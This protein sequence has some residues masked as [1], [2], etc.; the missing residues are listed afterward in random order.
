[1]ANLQSALSSCRNMMVDCIQSFIEPHASITN[2]EDR[3]RSRL[4]NSLIVIYLPL[5]VFVIFF[6]FIITPDD[7][8]TTVIITSMGIAV[9]FLIYL[10]GR[11]G[12]YRLSVYVTVSLGFGVIYFNAL[13]SGP[14]HFEIAYLLFLPLLGIVMFSLQDVLKIYIVAMILLIIFLTTIGDIEQHTAIDLF[15]FL[16]LAQGF[17]LFASYQRDRLE[18]NRRELILER[19]RR[20]L[21]AELIGNVSHDLKNPLTVIRNSVY[22]IKQVN[23]PERL[24]VELEKITIQ[25]KRLQGLIDDMLTISQMDHDEK[26]QFSNV[27]LS[28]LVDSVLHQLSTSAATK[29]IEVKAHISQANCSVLG[30]YE[31]L[32]RLLINLVENALNYTPEGGRVTV[33]LQPAAKN[34]IKLEVQDT[35]IGLSRE[36]MSKI[37]E[38][39]YRAD[40]ARAAHS[41][42]TGLGLSIVQRIVEHHDGE[43]KVDS[44]VGHGTTF[45]ILLPI[46]LST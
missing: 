25:T 12:R 34:N 22:F 31:E 7:T 20:E 39:F 23:T 27:D 14:P 4:L 42:G 5:A 44:R 13:N 16:L 1:M 45:C 24:E 38:R 26:P 30:N 8:T 6:R 37:F 21:V 32:E 3:Y 35:G 9:V 11:I 17:V 36:E 46:S 18:R 40:K 19:E 29:Q 2:D 28:E 15:V 33:M 10:L 43:I 41:S